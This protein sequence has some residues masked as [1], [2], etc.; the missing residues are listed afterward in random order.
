MLA[1]LLMIQIMET[2]FSY[3]NFVTI[4]EYHIELIANNVSNIV[5]LLQLLL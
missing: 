4:S 2:Y 5:M 1:W 3:Y